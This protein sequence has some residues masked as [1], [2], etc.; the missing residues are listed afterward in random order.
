MT[1][2]DVGVLDLQSKE[3]PRGVPITLRV[4]R[5]E[6][7]RHETEKVIVVLPS[8]K[9]M[10]L[11]GRLQGE[12]GQIELGGFHFRWRRGAGSRKGREKLASL[13]KR[14]KKTAV[15][16]PGKKKRGTKT[17]GSKE[18]VWGLATR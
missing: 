12:R 17:L 1:N 9:F 7:R 3:G 13:E 18:R 11:R 14:G 5:I 2:P 15:W 6:S 10:A 8:G 4:K 16:V